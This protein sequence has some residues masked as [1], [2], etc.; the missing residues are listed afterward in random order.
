MFSKKNKKKAFTLIEML[1]VIVIIGIL[2]AAI[3]PRLS[4]ARGRANDV[5][6]K[7]DLAQVA[8]ALVAY[9]IDHGSFPTTGWALTWISDV[10]MG[11]GMSSIPTDPNTS[12]P[13]FSGIV[14][15]TTGQ[16]WWTTGQYSYMPIKK[17]WIWWNAFVVMAWSETEW[18]SNRVVASSSNYFSNTTSLE[19]MV[20]CKTIKKTWANSNDN[21]G[22]CTYKE[23]DDVL[24]YIYLY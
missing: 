8:A 3:Y 17:W 23:W 11:A 1:I 22:N 6:R 9:Q 7:A 10:L 15:W 18:G 21:N 4:N 24:R 13:I 2:M 12:R 19:D 20:P 16:F 14:W 5:A